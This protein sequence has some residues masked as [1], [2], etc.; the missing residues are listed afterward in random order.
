MMKLSSLLPQAPVITA[1]ALA[2][3]TI[4]GYALFVASPYLLGPSLIV[5]SPLENSIVSSATIDVSG[6]TTRVAY[7]SLNDQPIPVLEDGAF[8]VERAYPTGYTVLVIRARDRFGRSR[9]EVIHFLNTHN[10]PV[11]GEGKEGR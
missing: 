6:R 10:P 8:A 3:L 7:L 11:H 1:G 9:E 2:L 5:T 4:G